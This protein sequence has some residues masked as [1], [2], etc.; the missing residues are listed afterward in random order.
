MK[1]TTSLFMERTNVSAEQ[2]AHEIHALLVGAG[3]RQVL[4]EYDANRE[5]SGLHF[6][7]DI[8][9]QH[10][11]F[12]MPVRTDK[13]F[14]M[15]KKKAGA[16]GRLSTEEIRIKAKRVAWR[17]LLR[18]VEAQLAFIDTGMA[19]PAEVF[20]P[21]IQVSRTQTLFQRLEEQKFKGLLSESTEEHE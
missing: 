9:N 8:E 4:T 10:V 18:W 16:S 17:Q 6:I 11:P 1:R 2:T 14:E 5:I 19:K 12:K 20:M 7:L 15:L 13:L 21:Y 3:A